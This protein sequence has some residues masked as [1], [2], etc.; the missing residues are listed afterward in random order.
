[1]PSPLPLDAD[2]PGAPNKE[3]AVTIRQ[4]SYPMATIRTLTTI[5]ISGSCGQVGYQN[6]TTKVPNLKGHTRYYQGLLT[7]K[8]AKYWN[9]FTCCYYTLIQPTKQKLDAATQKEIGVLFFR[10]LHFISFQPCDNGHPFSMEQ[11]ANLKQLETLVGSN[12]ALKV[13]RPFIVVVS[14]HLFPMFPEIPGNLCWYQWWLTLNPPPS[15]QSADRA[16]GITISAVG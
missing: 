16:D 2:C 8:G 13:G 5:E 10:L 4:C 12:W 7:S 1:M 6:L 15:S 9:D 14:P 11:A 3:S